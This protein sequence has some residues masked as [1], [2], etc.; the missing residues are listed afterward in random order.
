ME[1]IQRNHNILTGED[2]LEHLFTFRNFP[3]FMGCVNL[4]KKDDL[5]SDMSWFISK[6]TGLIQLNPLIPLDVLY[7][8]SHGSGVVGKIW[9]EHHMQF[10]S[11]ISKFNAKNILEIGAGHGELCRNYIENN[12][13]IKWT[14]IEPN[15][16]I[17]SDHNVTVIKGLFD[18]NFKTNEKI[19][20]V[21]HSHVME[22]LYEPMEIIRDISKMLKEGDLHLFSIPR[23]EEMLKRNYTNCLNFEH[24]VYLTEEYV[25]HILKLCDF[26]IIEKQYFKN[27]HSI[28]YATRKNKKYPIIE[29][30]PNSYKKNKDIFNSY[31][32]FHSQLIQKLNA[33]IQKHNGPV[34]LFGGHIFSQYLLGFGLNESKIECV[35]DN[36]SAKQGKRLYGSSLVVNSP[37]IL[38]NVKN[39]AVILKAGVYN[40]E[41][42]HDIIENINSNVVFWG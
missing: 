40:E 15:P 3:M 25:D 27:D 42:K 28:F 30:V 14:I 41:I 17:E 19:D 13:N 1:T 6:N 7:A 8:K 38:T 2:D 21:I 10:S 22:H 5:T 26:E 33:L 18:S 20:V 23:L 36:D 4:E 12:K 35:L 39:S 32:N 31:I 29:S 11:F 9:A 24:T 16:K 37:K 34:Y